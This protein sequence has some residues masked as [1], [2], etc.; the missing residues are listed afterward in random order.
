MNVILCHILLYYVSYECTG[1][2]A[3]VLLTENL[4]QSVMEILPIKW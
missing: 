4:L 2:S 1:T 3:S